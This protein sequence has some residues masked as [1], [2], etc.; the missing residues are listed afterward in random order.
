MICNKTPELNKIVVSTIIEK[1]IDGI[2]GIECN[3]RN[4]IIALDCLYTCLHTYPGACGSR[5]NN[6]Q[7][8]LMKYLDCTVPSAHVRFAAKCFNALQQVYYFKTK[9]KE[10]IPHLLKFLRTDLIC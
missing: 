6:L 1:L 2:K 9:I 4:S 8:Y 7:K 3:S 5:K 10:S